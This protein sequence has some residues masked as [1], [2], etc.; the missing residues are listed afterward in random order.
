MALL[1]FPNERDIEKRKELECVQS[2]A[3][4]WWPPG[5]GGTKVWNSTLHDPNFSRSL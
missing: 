5:L 2:P 3:W 1:Q 4:G